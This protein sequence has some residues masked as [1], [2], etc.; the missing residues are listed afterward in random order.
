MNNEIMWIIIGTCILIIM[1]LN[2]CKSNKKSNEYFVIT[3]CNR[4]DC[5][6]KQFGNN[7]QVDCPW[8]KSCL[9]TTFGNNS[10][11]TCKSN[12][13]CK[14]AIFGNRS[15]VNCSVKKGCKQATFGEGSCCDGVGCPDD[16]P[17]CE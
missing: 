14:K 13:S 8:K 12:Q 2:K 11:V 3:S 6:G 5:S 16:V 10:K 17:S 1:L 7:V 15:E 4:S 9:K